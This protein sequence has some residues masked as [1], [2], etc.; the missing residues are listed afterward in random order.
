MKTA[1]DFFLFGAFALC[2]AAAVSPAGCGRTDHRSR[3]G[4]WIEQSDGS[5][6]DA[7][8][9]ADAATGDTGTSPIDATSIDAA[10]DARRVDAVADA[11]ADGPASCAPLAACNGACVN[12]N[13]DPQSCGKCGLTCPAATPNCANGACVLTCATDAGPA[14]TNCNNACVNEAIDT[15]NCGRCGNTCTGGTVLRQRSLR[16]RPAGQSR[17]AT[18]GA[19]TCS[20]ASRTAVAAETTALRLAAAAQ[21]HAAPLLGR[22]VLG[23]L[24][25]RHADDLQRRV[26][27]RDQRQEQLRRLRERV[28]RDVDVRRRRVRLSRGAGVL[29]WRLHPRPGRPQQ[30]RRVRGHLQHRGGSR[31]HGRDVRVL[32]RRLAVRKRVPRSHLEQRELRRMQRALRG[33]DHLPERHLPVPERDSLQQRL[34]ADPERSEQLRRVREHLP[35]GGARVLERHVHDRMRRGPHGLQ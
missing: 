17:S 28:R 32:G 33:G 30:L 3:C 6:Y 25:R 24:R 31:L 4:R 29:Q 23:H 2:V 22:R 9:T 21:R 35:R 10:L 15:A 26:R 13:T 34:P 1:R 19:W 12:L 8:S 20:R 16:L 5:P 18:G 27:Q 7:T 14:L 11:P